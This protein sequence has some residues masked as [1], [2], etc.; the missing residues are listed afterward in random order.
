LKKEKGEKER[1][2]FVKQQL[3]V[4][5]KHEGSKNKEISEVIHKWTPKQQRITGRAIMQPPQ[6]YHYPVKYNGY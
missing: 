5:S 3:F 6:S 4:E 2:K 1:E